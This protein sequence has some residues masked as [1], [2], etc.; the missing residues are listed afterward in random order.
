MMDSHTVATGS[1]RLSSSMRSGSTVGEIL[2]INDRVYSARRL[3]S[4]RT[5]NAPP[6]VAMPV[7]L[8]ACVN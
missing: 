1:R 3:I 7:Q 8:F 5:R 6:R 4:A 2:Q